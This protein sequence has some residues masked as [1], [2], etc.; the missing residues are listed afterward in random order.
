MLLGNKKVR[1]YPQNMYYEN[2]RLNS[3]QEIA[4]QFNSFFVNIGDKFANLIHPSTHS[5]NE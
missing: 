3:K 4:Q 1:G 5:Y 2:I